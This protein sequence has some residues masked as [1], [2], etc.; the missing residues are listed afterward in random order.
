MRRVTVPSPST[1]IDKQTHKE[2]DGRILNQYPSIFKE[3]VMIYASGLFGQ[4]LEQKIAKQTDVITLLTSY[5]ETW[6]QTV[7]LLRPP[8]QK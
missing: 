8:H 7:S 3:C 1:A 6:P 2:T 5:L 4:T